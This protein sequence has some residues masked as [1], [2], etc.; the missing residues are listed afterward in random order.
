MA[1]DRQIARYGRQAVRSVWATPILA[2]AAI[3]A[4]ALAAEDLPGDPIAGRQ[5]ALQMCAECHIV[6]D[7]Q[8]VER[9]ALAPAF[10]DIAESPIATPVSLSAF[11]QTP[12]ASMPD[13]ILTP[14]ESDD[15]IAYILSLRGW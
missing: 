7:D 2:G 9:L 14:E 11:L 5:F 1:S 15:V 12:H 8:L 10:Q 4:V 6:A 3:A 13:L